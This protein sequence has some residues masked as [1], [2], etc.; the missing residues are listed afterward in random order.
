MSSRWTM[1]PRN[2][3]RDC[4]HTWFPR[5][6]NLSVTC[7]RCGGG[8]TETEAMAVSRA[9]GEVLALP[10]LLLFYLA[11]LTLLALVLAVGLVILPLRLLW[12][13]VA[14]GGRAAAAATPWVVERAKPLLTASRMALV[15]VARRGWAA[16]AF[17]G[18]WVGSARHDLLDDSEEP[19]NPISLT[20]K[21]VVGVVLTGAAVVLLIQTVRAVSRLFG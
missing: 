6:A 15:A 5:G 3:C 16:A 14:G 20:L 19:R 13:M 11:R 10:I 1:R 4:G 8:R 21:L 7:P 9:F 12:R 18:Q 17:I 2:G